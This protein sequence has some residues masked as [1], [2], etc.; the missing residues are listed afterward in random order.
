MKKL[1]RLHE[2]RARKKNSARERPSAVKFF[3]F[4]SCE[5]FLSFLFFNFNDLKMANLVFFLVLMCKCGE[6]R[7]KKNRRRECNEREREK[8]PGN[9]KER[10]KESKNS[11]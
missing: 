10:K 4:S 3:F 9:E 8:M 11:I 1:E 2:R 6:I 5:Q 7:D